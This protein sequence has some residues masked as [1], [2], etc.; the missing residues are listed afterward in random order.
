LIRNL[1]SKIEKF[2]KVIKLTVELITDAIELSIKELLK[3]IRHRIYRH[4]LFWIG[5]VTAFWGAYEIAYDAARAGIIEHPIWSGTWGFPIPHHWVFGFGLA[6]VMW[7]AIHHNEIE[8]LVME[9]MGK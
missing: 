8:K 3:L 4:T 2:A 9:M 6:G 5:Y 7:L 1:K